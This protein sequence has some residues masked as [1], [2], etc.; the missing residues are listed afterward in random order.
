MKKI[1]SFFDALFSLA[2]LLWH[3]VLL[4]WL[5]Y[6]NTTVGLQFLA[7]MVIAAHI[8]PHDPGPPLP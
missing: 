5:T 8:S 2:L 7:L 1:C 6:R 3:R 4:K